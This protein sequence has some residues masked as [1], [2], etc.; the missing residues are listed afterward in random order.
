MQVEQRLMSGSSDPMVPRL[1]RVTGRWREAPHTWTIEIESDPLNAEAAFAAGQ[2]NMLYAFGV[3]EIPISMSGDPAARG[4]LQH[5]VRAV[6]QVSAA[7]ARLQPGETIGLRGPFGTGWPLA[8]A[9]GRDVVIVAGG[10][11]LAP[12]RPAIYRVLAE[13]HR[14]GKIVILYGARSPD[15][16]L[17]SRELTR[18]REGRGVTVEV[19]VDHATDAWHGNV[20]AVTM[21][22]SRAIFDPRDSIAMVCGPEIMM[23]FAVAALRQAGLPND[24]IYLSMERNMKCAVGFCGHC[25]FGPD[26][27][28]R[29]GAVLPY[30]RVRR[31]MPVKE[32]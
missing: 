14:Y 23:R 10:L 32:V 26:F 29:D 20:G 18:W 8:A 24:A 6:G 1:A 9:V 3:G 19:T 7:L 4:R 2:F 17:F 22:I 5:T 12:L 15:D 28:C 30:T 31:L 13:R 25:Q 21:L 11:G 16:I 27:V